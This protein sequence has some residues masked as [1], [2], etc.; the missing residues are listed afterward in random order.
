MLERSLEEWIQVGKCNTPPEGPI[1]NSHAREGVDIGRINNKS[2][3]GATVI[4]PP[5]IL[6]RSFGPG[7]NLIALFHALTGVAIN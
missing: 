6:C 4:L 3:E 2:A 7:N 5:S 1:V